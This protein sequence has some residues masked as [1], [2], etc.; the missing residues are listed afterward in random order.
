M[1]PRTAAS[2]LCGSSGRVAAR[3]RTAAAS[4]T[5][6]QLCVI[7]RPSISGLGYSANTVQMS[8]NPVV[9]SPRRIASSQS[10]FYLPAVELHIHYTPVRQAES[11]DSTILIRQR[12]K[13]PAPYRRRLAWGKR[14]GLDQA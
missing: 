14:T 5:G 8:N 12:R 9:V 10:L 3:V 13:R 11:T 7:A 1:L 2:I 4:T 6:V